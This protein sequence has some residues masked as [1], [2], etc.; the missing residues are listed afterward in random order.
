MNT[1]VMTQWGGVYRH[2]SIFGSK[3]SCAEYKLHHCSVLRLSVNNVES[4]ATRAGQV[5][6]NF[7]EIKWTHLS[8]LV[9][10]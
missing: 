2:Y 4:A 1:A 3:H 5:R 10:T 6:G 9:K 7:K 8:E